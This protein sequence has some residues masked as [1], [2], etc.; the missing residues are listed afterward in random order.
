MHSATTAATH[1]LKYKIMLASSVSKQ[2]TTHA[3]LRRFKK[4]EAKLVLHDFVLPP[5]SHLYNTADKSAS[6]NCKTVSKETHR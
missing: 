2:Y 5:T 4:G 1:M 6:S 3:D